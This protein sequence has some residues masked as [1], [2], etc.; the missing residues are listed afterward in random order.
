MIPSYSIAPCILGLSVLAGCGFTPSREEHVADDLFAMESAFLTQTELPPTSSDSRSSHPNVWKVDSASHVKVGNTEALNAPPDWTGSFVLQDEADHGVGNHTTDNHL[1][2]SDLDDHDHEHE[3]EYGEWTFQTG[4]GFTLDPDMFLIPF[5]LEAEVAEDFYIG[6]SVQM[7]K[8]DSREFLSIGLEGR[9]E[10]VDPIWETDDFSDRIVPFVT[11]GLGAAY[12]EKRNRAGEDDDWAP[13]L[14]AGV[15]A[16]YLI[17]PHVSIG[18][19]MVFNWFLGDF[20]G[21]DTMFSWQ[22]ITLRFRF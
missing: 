11:G 2:H 20:V 17:N 22:V 7:A 3:H 14:N 21:E 6:P 16:E 9:V 1:V 13:M 5:V 4:A 18:S 19:R 8:S 15:G 10:L 12:L